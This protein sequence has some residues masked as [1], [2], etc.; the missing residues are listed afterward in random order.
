MS[1]FSTATNLLEPLNDWTLAVDNKDHIVVVYIDYAN[2]FVCVSHQ[3]LFQ[4]A[5]YGQYCLS[6]MPT[7]TD[8]VK[9]FDQRCAC[10]QHADVLK[11]CMNFSDCSS[12]FRSYDLDE[13]LHCSK[14]WQLNVA[15]KMLHS[16]G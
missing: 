2:A 10:K 4:A 14:T 7:V 9:L 16:A 8:I 5:V 13:L 11:L 3:K 15:Y 12:T 6:Y 1:S